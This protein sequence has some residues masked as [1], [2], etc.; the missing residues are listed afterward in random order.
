[1]PH[2][3]ATSTCWRFISSPSENSFDADREHQDTAPTDANVP[4]TPWRSIKIFTTDNITMGR[5]Q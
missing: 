1:M 3:Y 4:T 2:G 5:M